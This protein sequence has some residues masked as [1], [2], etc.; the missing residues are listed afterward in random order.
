M[1]S[2]NLS[3]IWTRTFQQTRARQVPSALNFEECYPSSIL[4]YT[5][6]EHDN[7][8]I[9]HVPSRRISLTGGSGVFD[10]YTTVGPDYESNIEHGIRK[11]RSSW[12]ENR[13]KCGGVRTQMY[14]AKKGIITEEMLF[15]ATREGVSAELVREEVAAGRAIIPAN[16]KHLELE[17]CVIGRKFMTK[18]NANIGNSAVVND[19][20]VEVEKLKWATMWHADTIMDLS[21]GPDISE[22]R[23]YIMRN[24]PVPVGT[25]PIYQ[26]LEKAG[27]HAEK[28]TWELFRDTLIEQAEQGVDYFT[29]HAGVLLRYVP[30]TKNRLTGIVSRGGS[31]HA[32][33]MLLEHR[34][35]FAYEHWD[36][37]LDICATYDISLSIGDGLRPG[38]IYDANDE[39]QF[40]ELLT[41]GELTR[42]AWEKNVQV[43]NEGP[44]HIPLHKI[45]E[46]MKK[47]LEWC[48]E[49]PFYT[50]GPLTTDVA[51][52]YDHITSAIGAATIGALGTSLLCYVTPKEH[53]GLPNK[54][55]VKQGMIAYKIAAHAA[56]LSKQHPAAQRW[57]DELS[58][59]RFE[60]RWRDQFALS[61][62]PVTSQQ[63]HD[64][65]LPH[66]GAKTAHF[67]SMCGSN[68]CSME[69]THQIRSMAD[70]DDILEE[71]S[72]G[73][74][75]MSALF[76]EKGDLYYL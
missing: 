64:E 2:L 70:E 49:A 69:I 31:I 56:D 67:C 52:G 6:V 76:K 44:G 12:I 18:V 46:N 40:A 43:M 34:E 42:R 10:A 54:D 68:F 57:D 4:N 16:K 48:H 7:G 58:W 17:P 37:I 3:P 21:T 47:Q 26:T 45:P 59:A 66:E 36:D 39:A 60:F 41:Q 38:S 29:I 63:Y 61:L 53:L 19:I 22:T 50:L 23:E 20:A 33:I 27:G 75:Q 15:A 25:V 1:G 71:K 72:A 8:S 28:I 55:D 9:L 5:E 24:S 30:L 74:A 14:Y 65:T 35:N 32:K 73:M 13:E 62:D 11:T 51:P